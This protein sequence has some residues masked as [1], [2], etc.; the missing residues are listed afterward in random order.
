MPTETSWHRVHRVIEVRTTG[1]MTIEEAGELSEILSQM[2]AEGQLHRPGRQMF[3]LFDSLE[4]QSVPPLYL[5]IKHALP[6]LR[7]RNRGP[8]FHITRN[9]TIR[10]ITELCSHVMKFELKVFNTR[11]EAIQ[12]LDDTLMREE[13]QH[14]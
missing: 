7:F 6:V 10:S 1:H 8:L 5:F 11:E 2:L 3:L 4:A 13:L 12:A 14:G 9:K